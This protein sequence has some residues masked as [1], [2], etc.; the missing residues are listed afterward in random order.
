[1]Q[2]ALNQKMK[3]HKIN[4]AKAAGFIIL[5]LGLAALTISIVYT[6]QISSFIGL[7]LVFWGI[8]LTYIQTEEYVKKDLLD[9]TTL[10]SLETISQI[11]QQME[12]VGKAVHLPPKYFKEPETVKV[13]VSKQSELKLPAPEQIQEQ[14]N[15]VFIE[16][17]QGLLL[18]PLGAAL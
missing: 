6:S 2:R 15:K 9:S 3:K 14:E 18:L 16:N 10:S 7:G 1:M 12:Y 5:F 13:F 8:I 4:L 11:I 17:P